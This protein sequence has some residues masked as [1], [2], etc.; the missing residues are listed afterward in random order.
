[1]KNNGF[2][3]LA[4]ILCAAIVVGCAN[5]KSMEKAAQEMGIK[6]NPNPLEVHGDTSKILSKKGQHGCGACICSQR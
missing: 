3:F 2:Y 1:M 4:A 5:L 6:S